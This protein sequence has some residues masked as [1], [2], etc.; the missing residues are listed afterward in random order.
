[1]TSRNTLPQAR[2]RPSLEVLE[3]RLAPDNLLSSLSVILPLDSLE[4]F[5]AG[6]ATPHQ[7]ASSFEQDDVALAMEDTPAPADPASPPP[8]Q[9]F[10]QLA[11]QPDALSESS[12]VVAYVQESEPVAQ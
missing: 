4:G 12:R 3:D 11:S 8:D 1:M 7:I 2:F 6:D 5:E 9:V 10:A